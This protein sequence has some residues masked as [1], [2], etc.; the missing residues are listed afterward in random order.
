MWQRQRYSAEQ[1]SEWIEQ[2]AESGETIADFCDSIGVA[3][4]TF[5]VW[6]RKL[7]SQVVATSCLEGG[8]T[9][10]LVEFAVAD[11]PSP[12]SIEIDLPCGALVRVSSDESLIRQVLGVLLEAGAPDAGGSSC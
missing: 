3:E 7:R 9:G 4:N 11:A 12:G 5:Y 1:W 8:L 6:R 10:G 2:Q